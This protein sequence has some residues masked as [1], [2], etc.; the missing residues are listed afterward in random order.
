M[1]KLLILLLFAGALGFDVDAQQWVAFSNLVS[2]TP[3]LNLLHS[4]AQSVSFEVTIPGIYKMDTVVNGVSFSRLMLPD[5]VAVSPI[6]SPELPVLTYKVAIPECSGI[7]ATYEVVSR[8]M[9]ASCWA[10]PVPEIVFAENPEGFPVATEQFAFDSLAY[11]QPLSG[12]EPAAVI[13]ATGALRAQRYAEIAVQPFEFCPVTRRLSVIEQIEVTISFSASQGDIRQNVGIFNKIA[14]GAFI[15]YE[16]D[17]MSALVNDKAFLEADSFP[18]NV[19]W[20]T[21]TDTAQ[22]KNIVAD[23]LIICADDFFEPNNLN[24]EVLRLARHRAYYNGFDVAILNVEHILSDAVGFYY[25]GIPDNQYSPIYK[26]E[27]RMR[28]CIRRI[29]EGAHANHTHDGRLAY[30]LLVGDNYEGNTGMP[31]SLD[32][33]IHETGNNVLFPSDYYFTCITKDATGEYDPDGDLFIGRLS[34]EDETQ[35]HNMVQKT[36]RHEMELSSELWRLS[37]GFTLGDHHPLYNES[38]VEYFGN[39]LIAWNNSFVNYYD[40]GGSIKEPTLNYL[41][42][43]V[44][45]AQHYGRGSIDGWGGISQQDFLTALNNDYKAPFINAVAFDTGHFDDEECLGEFLTRYSDTKGAVGYIGSSRKIHIMTAHYVPSNPLHF[46]ELF[47]I[48]LF[49][50]NISIAG[51]VSLKAKI[52]GQVP[53]TQMGKHARYGLNLFGDP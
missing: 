18:G 44:I 11:A 29:Y 53:S 12:D 9:M 49:S 45:F 39:L 1:K 36:I 40:W 27:Q 33:D 20:I 38:F 47:P 34:V 24:S 21:L 35:L 50:Q 43:G 8:Q 41:N 23:Y 4:N 22:A 37:T 25:E 26:K 51:E 5:G 31:T 10:Y 14:A 6:G 30:V 52:N 7:E 17:G 19:Q 3:E 13:I 48:Y 15:N 42:D 2:N 28:T 46:P 32:H 16:D